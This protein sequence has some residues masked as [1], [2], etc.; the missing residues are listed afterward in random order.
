MKTFS[1]IFPDRKS[2]Y[3]KTSWK[4]SSIGSFNFSNCGLNKYINASTLGNPGI[5]SPSCIVKA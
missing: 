1:K 4:H 3:W 2:K 5:E